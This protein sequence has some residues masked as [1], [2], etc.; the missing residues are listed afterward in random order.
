VASVAFS[1]AWSLSIILGGNIRMHGIEL[2]SPK[3]HS[4]S[5]CIVAL[6]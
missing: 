4:D 3:S 1:V 5:F 2:D 6:I